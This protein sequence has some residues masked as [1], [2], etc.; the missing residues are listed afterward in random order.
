MDHH[1][2]SSLL[3]LLL[4]LLLPPV[5]QVGNTCTEVSLMPSAENR[6]LLRPVGG[7]SV[8]IVS[9]RKSAHVNKY[10]EHINDA[11]TMLEKGEPMVV[12]IGEE[13]KEW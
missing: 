11:T 2:S 12:V 10:R 3:L 7:R 8:L 5:D 4:L 13:E 6:I 9:M 1:S